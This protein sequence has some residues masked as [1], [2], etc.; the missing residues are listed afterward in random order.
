MY[1]QLRMP[2]SQLLPEINAFIKT[3][4]AKTLQLLLP[5]KC[6]LFEHSEWEHLNV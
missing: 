1:M 2:L 6:I 5:A 4:L 3:K